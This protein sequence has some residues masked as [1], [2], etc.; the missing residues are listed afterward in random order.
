MVVAEMLGTVDLVEK[1][2]DSVVFRTCDEEK[3]RVVFQIGTSDAVRALQAANLVYVC[4]SYLF[5]YLQRASSMLLLHLI[6]SYFWMASCN[7]DKPR[8]VAE[9]WVLLSYQEQWYC[10][11]R[12]EHGLSQV[13]LHEWRNGCCTFVQAWSHPWCN[14]FL[15]WTAPIFSSPMRLMISPYVNLHSKGFHA[16]LCSKLGSGLPV[17]ITC[18]NHLFP[19]R[20]FCATSWL[21]FLLVYAS[22]KKVL[23]FVTS[24]DHLLN[25]YKMN[26]DLWRYYF[27]ASYAL[28]LISSSCICR[29]WQHW[30]ETWTFLWLARSVCWRL[31]MILW[32]LLDGLRKLELLQ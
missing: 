31:I 4:H 11:D 24:Q 17:G 13:I 30:R 27:E 16:F 7:H 9:Y 21:P 20:C 14:A 1:G 12:C 2:T 23:H 22:Y 6:F 26:E 5:A 15:L 3:T 8:K 19:Q 28:L 32:S 10:C 25:N 29:F 18:L